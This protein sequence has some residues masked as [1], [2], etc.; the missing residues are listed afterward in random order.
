MSPSQSEVKQKALFCANY[1]SFSRPGWGPLPQP[2]T[3]V[4]IV[5]HLSFYHVL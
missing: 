3:K 2:A 1:W 5:H 4:P